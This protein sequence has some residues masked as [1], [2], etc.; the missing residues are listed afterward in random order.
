[1][2]KISNLVL[3]K[4]WAVACLAIW[5][6]PGSAS[7][8]VLDLSTLLPNP[9]A[10]GTTFIDPS[11][12]GWDMTVTSNIAGDISVNNPLGLGVVGG[13]TPAL[14]PGETITFDFSSAAALEGFTLMNGA[15]DYVT[16]TVAG[17]PN[18]GAT[19]VILPNAGGGGNDFFIGA[20]SL[21][22]SLIIHNSR[23]SQATGSAYRISSLTFVPIP[24]AAWLFG[25]GLGLL[26]WLKRRTT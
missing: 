5:I 23:P 3:S 13:A 22:D 18:V 6:L 17:T 19:Q 15:N 12:L 20:T 4:V 26:V 1:M 11:G 25:S 9:F 2:K 8:Y 14:D 21:A 16:Y 24:A 7:A 10:S